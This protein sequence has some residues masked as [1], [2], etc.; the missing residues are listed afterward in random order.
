M[1]STLRNRFGIPGVISVIALVFAMFGGAY[2]ASNSSNGGKATASKAKRGPRGPQ[3]AT[4]PAGPTGPAG[5]KGEAG[6]PGADGLPGSA[7]AAGT[8]VTSTLE[9]PGAKCEEGGTKFVAGTKTTYA[10]NGIPG[11]DG[12]PW[13]LGGTLPKDSTEKG[14]F[15]ISA[16]NASGVYFG[17]EAD[18]ISFNV[19][20]AGPL[21]ADHTIVVPT[22]GSNP[23]CTGSPTN[24]TAASGYLCIYEGFSY[25]P[26]GDPLSA[27]E[28]SAEPLG[29]SGGGALPNGT[30]IYYLVNSPGSMVGG[31]WAV[32]G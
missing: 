23:N 32:T 13:T 20:L 16:P 29:G 10:C 22:G 25:A 8:S 31:S 3:G 5:A 30:T 17:Y 24:P 11:T 15:F 21:A 6:A 27:P 26:N 12:S 9:P 2:A 4:G 7:G 19:P 14:S 18:S 28:I 1:F